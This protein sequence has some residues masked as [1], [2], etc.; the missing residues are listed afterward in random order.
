MLLLVPHRVSTVDTK[1]QNAGLDYVTLSFVVIL[2]SSEADSPFDKSVF[3]AKIWTQN[4]EPLKTMNPYFPEAHKHTDVRL[5]FMP[6]P[7]PDLFSLCRQRHHTL[8]WKEQTVVCT[9]LC[10]SKP[11]RINT[12]K[13]QIFP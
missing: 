8:F 6:I 10:H 7:S 12:S 5:Q 3:C 11:R 13:S 1:P 2:T 9:D 4:H